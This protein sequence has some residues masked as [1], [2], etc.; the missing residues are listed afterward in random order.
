MGND[1][2]D[3]FDPFAKC[4]GGTRGE[5]IEEEEE[6]EE[7]EYADEEGATNTTEAGTEQESLG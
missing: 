4:S 6:R 2:D 5:G 3:M 7:D 1:E